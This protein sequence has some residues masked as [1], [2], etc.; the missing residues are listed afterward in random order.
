MSKT[1]TLLPYSPKLKMA[2]TEIK[3]ILRK[4]DIAGHI[5]LH[6]PGFC[7]YYNRIDP[8]YSCAFFL[9]NEIRFRSRLKDHNGNEEKQK[10]EITNTINMVDVLSGSL[11]QNSLN[12]FRAMEVLK[13]HFAIESEQG[14][15]TG[16]S[17]IFN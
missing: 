13:K 16:E 17:E 3:A 6:T 1:P 11:G 9:N 4:H 12:F 8:S 2:M 14:P 15:V 7:E 5:T 10:A